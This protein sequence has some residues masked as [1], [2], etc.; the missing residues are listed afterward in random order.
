MTDVQ[1]PYLGTQLLL[2]QIPDYGR[3]GRVKL[4]VN[5]GGHMHYLRDDTRKA[6]R[7]AARQLIESS[8]SAGA[9]PGAQ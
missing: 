4:I 9:S 8:G 3:P 5:G 7:D 2:D 6:L 1:T